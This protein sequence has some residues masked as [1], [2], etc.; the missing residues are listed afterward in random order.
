MS[1]GIPALERAARADAAAVERGFAPRLDAVRYMAASVGAG[2]SSGEYIRNKALGAAGQAAI[3]ERYGATV[4]V[5]Q[6]VYERDDAYVDAA[7]FT[8]SIIA[9][10]GGTV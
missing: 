9:A 10:A 4:N 2:A 6:N 1:R 3:R 5:T 7:I 8:R